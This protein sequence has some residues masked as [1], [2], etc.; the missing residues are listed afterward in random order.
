VAPKATGV[1]SWVLE[2]A[3][4]PQAEAIVRAAVDLVDARIADIA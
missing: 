2:Q 4:A 1:A 3:E